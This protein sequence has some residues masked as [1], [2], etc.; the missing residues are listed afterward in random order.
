M[1]KNVAELWVKELRSGKY[2][3]TKGILQDGVGFCCLG[4]LCKVGEDNGVFVKKYMG[5]LI[6]TNLHTRLIGTNLQTQ[7]DI[8]E[9]SGMVT[10]S[11][12]FSDDVSLI[13]LNDEEDYTFN[14]IADVIERS[15][16]EL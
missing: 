2:E 12:V 1:N 16:E 14:Q 7:K 3:K 15:W 4:V 5:E 11:G 8:S 9:W 13:N 10:I 6:G